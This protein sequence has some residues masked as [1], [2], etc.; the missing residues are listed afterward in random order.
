MK[1]I[2]VLGAVRSSSSMIAYL[3]SN[4]AKYQWQVIVGD[5]SLKASQERVGNH[6][7]GEAITFDVL[8]ESSALDTVRDSDVVISLLPAHFH[9]KVAG[10]CLTLRKHLLTAS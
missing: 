4:A 1:K 2:L 10:Y 8:N 6:A 7:S 3:L 5:T 9:P